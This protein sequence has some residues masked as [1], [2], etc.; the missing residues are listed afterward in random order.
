MPDSQPVIRVR[1]LSKHY[2]TH[3]VVQDVS[4][5]LAAGE[6]L[7]LLGPS[8]CGKTTLLK[9]LNRLIE[10]DAGTVEVQ[11][12]D[13]RNQRPEVLRRGIGY[14]I[15]QVGLLPHLTVA[16]NVAV[17]PKLLGH[18]AAEVATRTEELLTRLHLPPTRYAGQYPRQLSGGQQQRVGLARA[19]AA[20]PPI[21][22]LDEPFGALDP[23]TRAGIRREFQELEELRQKTVVLVTHDVQE[24]F[25]LADRILLLD[26]GRV[27][28]LGTPRELLFQPAND[29]V[30]RFF[31]AEQL[32]LQ[33]RTL[34]LNDLLP[35]LAKD[36]DSNYTS[37]SKP[38]ANTIQSNATVQQALEV[39]SA[40]PT[41]APAP[42]VA[43]QYSTEAALAEAPGTPPELWLLPAP[44][45]SAGPAASATSQPAALPTTAPVSLTLPSLMAAF[46]QVSQ[47]LQRP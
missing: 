6:T 20:N 32:T 2:G 26:G 10:P 14:V 4:F 33:L 18:P 7:V 16:E 27:Q 36:T 23:I 5:D 38:A 24:A 31:E 8:G 22:L 29:F 45:L 43:S 28:Q 37:S 17:V 25:E 11:G 40:L 41:P 1:G 46:G 19:L 35:Y 44:G 21:I 39:L 42:V 13:V 12:Q 9:T 34:T 3:A 47:R 15:Q 30:R